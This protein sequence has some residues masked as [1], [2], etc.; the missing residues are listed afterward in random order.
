MSHCP[1]VQGCTPGGTE[2]PGNRMSRAAMSCP[3]LYCSGW[4][5][6]CQPLTAACAAASAGE[7]DSPALPSMSLT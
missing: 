4:H 6:R 5:V 2:S 7:P 3:G 1:G